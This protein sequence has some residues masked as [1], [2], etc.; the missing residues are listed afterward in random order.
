M[1]AAK[2]LISSPDLLED[3]DTEEETVAYDAPPTVS[4][5]PEAVPELVEKNASAS[6]KNVAVKRQR[7]DSVTTCSMKALIEKMMHE[8]RE[9]AEESY[10]QYA[11]GLAREDTLKKLLQK[12]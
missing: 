4:L 1:A 11:L 6:K 7:V 3:T 12:Y 10:L 9:S 5:V 2:Y 8:A